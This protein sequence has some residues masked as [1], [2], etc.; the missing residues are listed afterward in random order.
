MDAYNKALKLLSMREHSIKELER[1]LIDKGYDKDDV[2]QAISKLLEK[3]WLSDKRFAESY[4]RSRLKKSPEGKPF[5]KARLHQTGCADD[6]IDDALSVAWEEK[7]WL[8]PLKGAIS[9]RE[10]KKGLEDAISVYKKKGFTSSE[11]KE[12][13]ENT[14]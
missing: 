6:E 4:I 3:N 11:I 9:K 8:L 7:A 1:K 13:I 10:A 14:D 5:L 12:A 2:N